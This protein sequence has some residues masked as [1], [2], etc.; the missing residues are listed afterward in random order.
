MVRKIFFVSAFCLT[1]LF[2]FAQPGDPG[3]KP[4]TGAVPI[5]GGIGILVAAGALLGIRKVK[6]LR[7]KGD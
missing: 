4:G 7:N 3:P 5:D 1:A 6:A 2:V